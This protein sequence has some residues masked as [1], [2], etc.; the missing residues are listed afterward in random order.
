MRVR[1]ISPHDLPFMREM[2]YEAAYWRLDGPR[3]PIDEGLAHPDLAKLV[4]DWGRP[5][6][7]GVVAEDDAGKD[8]GAAWYRLWTPENHSYGFVEAETPELAI[9]V[10]REVRGQGVGTLLLEAL[11]ARARDSGYRQLSLSVELDN[12][13]RALYQAHGFVPIKQ[14]DGAETMVVAIEAR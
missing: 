6:D 14:A 5:G 8:A 2:L 9:A 13:A 1:P 11:I 10:R 12:P 4:S 7:D 3:P